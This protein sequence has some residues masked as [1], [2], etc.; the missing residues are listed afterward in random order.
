MPTEHRIAVGV[1]V[2]LLL[3]L[4]AWGLVGS[5]LYVWHNETLQRSAAAQ[6]TVIAQQAARLQ[7]YEAA[8]RQ[9]QEAK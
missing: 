7:Q 6:A 1:A 2:F 5:V 3:A 4:A 8:I 9:L